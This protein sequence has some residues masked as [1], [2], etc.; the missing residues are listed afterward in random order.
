M[1]SDCGGYSSAARDAFE[2]WASGVRES[3]ARDEGYAS[4][5]SGYHLD[6]NVP[7]ADAWRSGGCHWSVGKWREFYNDTAN[8]NYLPASVNLAK[9]DSGP[10]DWAFDCRT[11]FQWIA[12]KE[13][14]G[15]H[16][17]ARERAALES[18]VSECGG[19][20]SASGSTSPRPTPT[21][22]APS[23]PWRRSYEKNCNGPWVDIGEPGY[24]GQC[25]DAA[26]ASSPSS[27]PP[28]PT[29][30]SS[31]GS[32]WRRSYEKNCNGRWVDVGEPGY[33]GRCY[34]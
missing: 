22:A 26:A 15:L 2:G 17:D 13:K 5:P 23:G 4:P 6:H 28:T 1:G 11:A 33:F 31:S 30:S 20:P 3:V 10:A 16:S 14:W 19:T 18:K 25:Y 8:L 29:P 7:V 34:E 9:S 32:S 27:S 12:T 21:P 24:F